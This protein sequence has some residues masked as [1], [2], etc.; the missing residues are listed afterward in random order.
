[1]PGTYE[2]EQ[3]SIDRFGSAFE[4]T[5]YL[6]S[7][8]DIVAHYKSLYPA[9]GKGSWKRHLVADLSKITGIKEKSLERRFDPSR[10]DK[11]EKQTKS[12]Y[13]ALGKTLG[14]QKRKRDYEGKRM[15]IEI[16]A[17]IYFSKMPYKRDIEHDYSEAEVKEMMELPYDEALD[18]VMGD[19]LNLDTADGVD[20]LKVD[21]EFY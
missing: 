20:I 6:S 21:I 18:W 2:F 14:E 1:M 9:R 12:Q 17:I 3:D 15:R 13:E 4:E 8:Q 5:Y 11:P 10:I 19:Y 16:K 7:K